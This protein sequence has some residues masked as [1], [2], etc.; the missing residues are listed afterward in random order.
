MGTRTK[1][2][3]GLIESLASTMQYWG[4]LRSSLWFQ[5]RN[6]TAWVVRCGSIRARRSVCMIPGCNQYS[7]GAGGYLDFAT[8]MVLGWFFVLFGSFGLDKMVTFLFAQLTLLPTF[9]THAPRLHC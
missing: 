3:C 2:L 8:F 1:D 4:R 5:W 9:L 7:W 6:G